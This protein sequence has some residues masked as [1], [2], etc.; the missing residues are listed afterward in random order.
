MIKVN[1]LRIGIL[2]MDF[3]DSQKY[4][5]IECI[6]LNMHDRYWV[7]YRDNSIK[8]SVESLEPIRLTEEWLLKFGFEEWDKNAWQKSFALSLNK[9]NDIFCYNNNSINV[10]IK[11]VHQ[12][13]NLYWCLCG[14]ELKLDH[15]EVR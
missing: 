10:I 8:C 11:Y 15:N 4:H 1:E 3:E 14:E 12:L 7:S 13:Q 2:V 5:P 6:Y 9:I